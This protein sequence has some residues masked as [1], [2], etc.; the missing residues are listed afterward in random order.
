[1]RIGDIIVE[2]GLTGINCTKKRETVRA[3][4]TNK[5]MKILLVYSHLFNDYTFPGG[6]IKPNETHE[7]AL[8]RELYEEL[9]VTKL[10]VVSYLG[11]TEE[12]RY[13]I[14]DSDDTYCQISYYYVTHILEQ[15][16][17][18][19]ISRE[20]IHGLEPRWILADEAIT[21]N[22]LVIKDEKHNQKGL[23]TVLIRENEVLIKL[24]EI[25][26]HEK[27]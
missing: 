10:K 18:H 16:K 22:Q 21:H 2:N 1:M 3:V 27:I 6:G 5:E 24:K 23:K 13:G 20:K 7:K 4:I 15:G 26:I 11:H 19:L 17:Q 14:H 9:G 12:I 25:L 8:E